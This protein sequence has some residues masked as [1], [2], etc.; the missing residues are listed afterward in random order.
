MTTPVTVSTP[1]GIVSVVAC[2]GLY[3]EAAFAEGEI[4][5]IIDKPMG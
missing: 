3:V 2:V 4:F 1:L 5:R